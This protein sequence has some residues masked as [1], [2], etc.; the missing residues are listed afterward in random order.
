M[1]FLPVFTSQYI[2]SNTLVSSMFGNNEGITYYG[3]PGI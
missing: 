1:V 2:P 3:Y